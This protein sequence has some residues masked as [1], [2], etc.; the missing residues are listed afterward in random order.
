MP[1]MKPRRGSIKQ[2]LRLSRINFTLSIQSVTSSRL[3]SMPSNLNARISEPNYRLS[4]RN[5]TLSRPNVRSSQ[6][7]LMPSNRNATISGPICT[8]FRCNFTMPRPMFTQSARSA[9]FWRTISGPPGNYSKRNSKAPRARLRRRLQSCR[10]EQ[11]PWAP[12]IKR[13][14]KISTPKLP[15]YAGRSKI[16]KP[17][18]APTWQVCFSEH[19]ILLV[20]TVLSIYVPDLAP[21]PGP[22]SKM[23]TPHV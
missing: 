10:K 1:S 13:W 22:T 9:P 16:C 23:P 6:P 19:V 15:S 11:C 4:G 14:W 5:F 7:V 21:K 20:L 8:V 3:V 2:Q 12:L 18:T 17:I